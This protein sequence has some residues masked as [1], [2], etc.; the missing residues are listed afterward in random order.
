ME[1]VEASHWISKG[2]IREEMDA[3]HRRTVGREEWWP[4][5]GGE[6]ESDG[7][8]RIGDSGVGEDCS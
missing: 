4:F 7:P 1:T 2:S 5:S 6:G 8:G 3:Q